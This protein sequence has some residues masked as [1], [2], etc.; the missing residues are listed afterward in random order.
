MQQHTGQH[1]LSAVLIELFNY[2]TVSFHMSAATS[3]IDIAAPSLDSKQ[4][5]RAAERCA[6]IV[7]E[8]RPVAISYQDS[9]EEL[10]LRKASQRTGTLRIVS[11]EGLDRSACGGT[12]VRS[13]GELGPVLLRKVEKMRGNMRLE[14]VCGLRALRQA[15]ADFLLLEQISRTVSVP[16]QE[17]PE[18][19]ASLAGKIKTLEKHGQ[20]LAAELAQREGRELFQATAPDAQGIR[21]VTHNGPIDD[22]TRARAQAFIA[23]GKAVFLAISQDPPSLLLAAS[24]DAGIHAGDR[25]KAF[26]TAAGGRGG[27][28]QSLAQGSVPAAEALRSADALTSA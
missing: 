5:D 25:V 26:V 4:L 21:R 17:A 27:G 14:F 7:A 24:P 2:P 12:H 3:T 6:E 1:L 20:R 9:T 22:A 13:T 10:G 15:R 8:A 11:I 23:G 28:N 16:P 18:L 19:V